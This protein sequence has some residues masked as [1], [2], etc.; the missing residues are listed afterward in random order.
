[1]KE[2]FEQRLRQRRLCLKWN[3]FI[4]FRSA[5]SPILI[6]KVNVIGNG[7]GEMDRVTAVS[8][9]LADYKELVKW[10]EVSLH[11]QESSLRVFQFRFD[12]EHLIESGDEDEKTKYRALR[13]NLVN[14]EVTKFFLRLTDK[15]FGH[16]SIT[17]K[18]K[19]PKPP[20]RAAARREARVGIIVNASLFFLTLL[21]F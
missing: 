17:R 21:A 13:R 12:N 9:A 3:S 10:R 20:R 1:M 11:L 6:Q 7:H 8:W 5:Q 14:K 2:W 18:K 16:I 15:K 19:N 4:T